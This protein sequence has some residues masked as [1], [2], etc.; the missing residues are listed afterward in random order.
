MHTR[1]SN[2]SPYELATLDAR[3]GDNR[4]AFEWLDAAYRE[5]NLGLM[6]LNT[7]FLLDPVRSDP[8]FA[9]LVRKVDLPQ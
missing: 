1:S 4:R 8:R 9:E 7:D 3:L 5:R 2:V 6:R